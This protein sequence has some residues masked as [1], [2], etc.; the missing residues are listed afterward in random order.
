MTPKERE[1]YDETLKR[2]SDEKLILESHFAKGLEEGHQKGREEEKRANA[3][4]MLADG[5]DPAF[6]MKYTGLTQEELDAL[7]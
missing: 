6:V 1:V 5:M 4:T 7:S 2:L 3:R